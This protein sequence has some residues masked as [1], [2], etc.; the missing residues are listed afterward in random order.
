[1][2]A[3][4]TVDVLSCPDAPQAHHQDDD[5]CLEETNRAVEPDTD[6]VVRALDMEAAE[7]HSGTPSKDVSHN[8]HEEK[9]APPETIQGDAEASSDVG[10]RPVGDDVFIRSTMAKQESR[11]AYTTSKEIKDRVLP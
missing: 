1:V 5:V 11:F 10:V 4:V 2:I 6:C 7:G 9:Q 3:A 8:N